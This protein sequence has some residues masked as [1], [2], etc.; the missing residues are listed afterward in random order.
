M[1]SIKYD[2]AEEFT[3]TPNQ[4]R[5]IRV[6]LKLTKVALANSLG[7]TAQTVWNWETGRKPVGKDNAYRIATIAQSA[8]IPYDESL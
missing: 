8:G 6:S 7:V 1:S 4:V 3:L 2:P 5:H